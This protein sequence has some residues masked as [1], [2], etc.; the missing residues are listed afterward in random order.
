[1]DW[2]WLFIYPEYNIASVNYLAIPEQTPINFQITSQGAMNS[3]WI[4]K[5]GSQIYAMAGMSTK[6]H[7]EANSTGTYR[8]GAANI[9]GEGFADMTFTAESMTLKD[10]DSWVQ[11]V[12]TD[13]T[14]LT[15]AVFEDLSAPSI[16]NEAASYK[17]DRNDLYATVLASYM[18]PP[19][20]LQEFGGEGMGH[21]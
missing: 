3:F 9:N 7:L 12:R 16:A 13:G 8:G 20:E 17:L 5:L 15:D 1:M 10:F 14:L 11:S 18:V 6:L 2:K 19:K 4:P 21:N